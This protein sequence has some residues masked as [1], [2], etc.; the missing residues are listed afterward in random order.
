MPLLAPL[1]EVLIRDAAEER[2]RGRQHRLRQ[3]QPVAAAEEHGRDPGKAGNEERRGRR[4]P[5]RGN[6]G[7]HDGDR[8]RGAGH[9]HRAD[10]GTSL[11]DEA[12][13]K[14]V[15]GHRRVDL[16]PRHPA[17]RERRLEHVEQ[18]GRGGADEDDLVAEHRGIDPR[19]LAGQD[20]LLGVQQIEE[21]IRRVRAAFQIGEQRGAPEVDRTPE[22]VENA[23]RRPHA[24]HLQRHHA[25]PVLEERTVQTH[26]LRTDP[27]HAQRGAHA[28]RRHD[29]VMRADERDGV[30][31]RTVGIED[32]AVVPEP[33]RGGGELRERRQHAPQF[34]DAGDVE[35]V[36]GV[37]ERDVLD[38]AV[39]R[40]VGDEDDVARGLHRL[41]QHPIRLGTAQGRSAEVEATA[42]VGLR[43]HDV[44][45]DDLRGRA[46]KI[47]EKH[48][49]DG[50]RP[51]PASRIGLQGAERGLVDLDERDVWTRGL[52]AGRLG[53][54][55]VVRP[56]LDER[57][58]AEAAPRDRRE[59]AV[60]AQDQGG[61][62]DPEE[63]G[64]DP[65]GRHQR[66][67]VAMGHDCIIASE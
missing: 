2:D 13:R 29:A 34:V 51:G 15:V 50:A 23:V 14:N 16:H 38:L 56:P 4:R 5:P 64:S 49:V 44:V 7:R 3:I 28:E 42:G 10:A 41:G 46:R 45:G 27:R 6:G 17:V 53:Q 60:A 26:V 33:R 32:E 24:A 59:Q 11:L 30:A 1:D 65:P 40:R 37:G 31:Q 67:S 19:H 52:G 54:A 35:R 22:K 39:V 36:A 21:G 9:R 25:I 66:G 47:V 43:E 63:H 55:P 18:P 12:A 48:R 61:G 58:W 57:E 62:S 8:Q 20:L